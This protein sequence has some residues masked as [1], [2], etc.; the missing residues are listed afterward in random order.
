MVPFSNSGN[1]GEVA[2]PISLWSVSESLGVGQAEF[3]L[4]PQLVVG[5]V[6]APIRRQVRYGN[7]KRKKFHKG[8][9]KRYGTLIIEPRYNTMSLTVEEAKKEIARLQPKMVELQEIN[10]RL[11]AL[12]Q[13]VE[14]GEALSSP[15]GS[16]SSV[17]AVTVTPVQTVRARAGSRNA[18]TADLAHAILTA[19]GPLSE[20][21]LLA[22]MRA[23]DWT[24]PN[25]DKAAKKAIYASLH[26]M[27]AKCVYSRKKWAA[28]AG[29]ER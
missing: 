14:L 24:G 2:L 26:R 21:E 19:R 7:S 16:H 17:K 29:Q 5:P 25:E 18:P 8:V 11:S 22:Q 13:F 9:D 3:A 23:R 15:N 28:I 27:S 1:I 10:K 4:L 12:Q 20:S 6:E